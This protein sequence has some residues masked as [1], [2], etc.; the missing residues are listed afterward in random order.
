MSI[1]MVSNSLKKHT[2]EMSVA[3]FKCEKFES[4]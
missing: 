3:A 2:S 4:K 1:Y